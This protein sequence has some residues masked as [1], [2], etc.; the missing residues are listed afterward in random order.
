MKKTL[1][2][3]CLLFIAT[4]MMAQPSKGKI[5]L[6]GGLGFSGE[7]GNNTS[8][9]STNSYKLNVS[10][11]VGYFTGN[12]FALGL[13][14][15]WTYAYS[16][17]ENNSAFFQRA[18][19]RNMIY[20]AGVFSRWYHPITEKFYF[21]LKGGA[22]YNIFNSRNTTETNNS[23]IETTSNTSGLGLSAAPA[24]EF[25]PTSRIGIEA[26]FGALYFN[27]PLKPGSNAFNYGL[28]LN[29]ASFTLGLHF[30]FGGGKTE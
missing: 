5:I 7:K 28:D 20:G 21:V 6:G 2:T 19:S 16:K 26:G 22:L 17:T 3:A 25:F 24:F 15:G 9:F 27:L 13:Q 11:R 1:L 12:R 18:I 8:T 23:S 29:T 30:Y 14:L 10:P 4:A